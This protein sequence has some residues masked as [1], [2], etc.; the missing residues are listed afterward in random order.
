MLGPL[1]MAAAQ[2]CMTK[3][4]CRTGHGADVQQGMV[5]KQQGPVV[6]GPC[7]VLLNGV[8]VADIP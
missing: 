8:T 4:G 2:S 3:G 1:R 5:Y 6:T 7:M